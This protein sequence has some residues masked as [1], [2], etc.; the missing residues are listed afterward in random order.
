MNPAPL[1]PK[2][3]IIPLDQ[4]ADAA[5]FRLGDAIVPSLPT[6]EQGH[7]D[8]IDLYGTPELIMWKTFAQDS[9]QAC[10]ET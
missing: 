10:V 2:P 9:I 4:T 7:P 8:Q 5:A 3:R 6:P 1:G